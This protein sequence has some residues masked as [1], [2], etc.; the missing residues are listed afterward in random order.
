[1]DKDSAHGAFPALTCLPPIN[2]HACVHD[3]VPPLATP[4]SGNQE[5]LVQQQQLWLP[6]VLLLC[7]A[8]PRLLVTTTGAPTRSALKCPPPPLHLYPLRKEK[9]AV[10]W[11][12]WTPGGG[13]GDGGGCQDE[14]RYCG[15][16]A[17]CSASPAQREHAESRK[18]PHWSMRASELFGFCGGRV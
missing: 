8:G 13:R 11:A 18:G 2:L 3:A 15:S 12:D 4:L 16:P 6:W 7:S 5:S 17:V 10:C 1:M 9:A 14:S